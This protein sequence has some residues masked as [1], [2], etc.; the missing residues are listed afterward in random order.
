MDCNEGVTSASSI[1]MINRN[2]ANI[3]EEIKKKDALVK[4]VQSAAKQDTQS[5][6]TPISM[7]STLST[8]IKKKK[9]KK[10]KD[11]PRRPLSA[12]NIFFRA[13]RARIL[14]HNGS[15][16]KHEE[17]SFSSLG[18]EVAK[19]WKILNE[20]ERM[21][22]SKMAEKEMVR[23]RNEMDDYHIGLARK[24]RF[25]QN[26]LDNS[27]KLGDVALGKIPE[28]SKSDGIILGALSPCTW[29]EANSSG[30]HTAGGEKKVENGRLSSLSDR[31]FGQTGS[32]NIFDTSLNL[33]K[34]QNMP[35]VTNQQNH[36]ALSNE[37]LLDLLRQK[38]QT[39]R[40]L[41]PVNF[42]STMGLDLKLTQELFQLQQHQRLENERQLLESGQINQSTIASYLR[43]VLR[44]QAN[45]LEVGS[46]RS[47]LLQSDTNRH[48]FGL[49]ALQH[50]KFPF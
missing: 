30:Y 35:C 12:Y 27:I 25:E 28:D 22:Y 17:A 44:H 15:A 40:L 13:E 37:L 9:R 47:S 26:Q 10:P 24:R 31:V 41:Q 46:Y 21:E 2:E 34:M 1:K 43:M 48:Q 33:I 39:H 32:S 20:Q 38:G 19:R 45:S 3:V 16:R 7:T 50:P 4:T 11:M 23:Y 14:L 42:G 36:F 29:V 49:S 5:K 8:K 6:E 18:K